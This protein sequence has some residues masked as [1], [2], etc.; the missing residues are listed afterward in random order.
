MYTLQ[1]LLIL[2]TLLGVFDTLKE[3]LCCA[4]FACYVIIF[5]FIYICVCLVAVH[6]IA[7][8]KELFPR[9]GKVL[10]VLLYQ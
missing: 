6:Y 4:N 5:S 8:S 1:F 9:V 7:C 2:N 10:V 3:L